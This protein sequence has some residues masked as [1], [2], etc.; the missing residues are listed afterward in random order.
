MV[1]P[2]VPIL[3]ASVLAAGPVAL[4]LVE[5]TAGAV[6]AFLQLWSGRHADV[7]PGKR[8]AMVVAGYLIAVTAR[9]LMGFAGSW[10]SVVLLR[11]MD[12]LGKG[13]RGA[14]RDA[15]LAEAAGPGMRGR[16]YGVNRAMDYAG[17]VGGTLIAAAVLAWS[18]LD[19]TQVI[20][21][22][23]IPGVAV[24]LL[25]AYLPVPVRSNGSA[26]K[27]PEKIAPFAWTNL[28]PA[29]RQFFPLLSLFAM[30]RASEVFIVLRGHEL[31]LGIVTL[32]L[33]WAYLAALQTATASLVAVWADRVS[34]R[35]LTILNWSGLA[36]GYFAIALA[37]NT[38]ALW[39]AVGLYGLLSGAGEGVERA[40]VSELAPDRERGAAFGWY[41]MI[42]G[43]AA[44]PAGLLFGVI[45]SFA[46][47]PGAFGTV[48]LVAGLSAGLLIY[49]VPAPRAN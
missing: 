3:L 42:N 14:P 25:L 15:I 22:S 24:A 45:W 21:L 28:P 10:L 27:Q 35:S 31:G 41:H 7:Q 1:A 11:C 40:F 46:G 43:L 49:L 23:A 48:A 19:I 20:V 29:L 44:I 30:A 33:L 37:P 8:K 32:L 4:G 26:V 17:A 2:L 47:A 34:K 12:R 6:A 16:A 38:L 13:I 18:S 39:L 9:P 36:A 5:G